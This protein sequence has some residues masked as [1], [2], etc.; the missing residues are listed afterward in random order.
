MISN[1]LFEIRW[2]QVTPDTFMYGSLLKFDDDVTH[3]ENALMPSGVTIHKWRMVTNHMQDKMIP[4]LPIL[5]RNHTYHFKFEYEVIPE[6]SIYFKLTFKRKNGTICDTQI[7]QGHEAIV[8]YPDEA[9]QYDIDMINAASEQ[10]TFHKITIAQEDEAERSTDLEI[11]TLNQKNDVTIPIN[12]LFVESG[13]V[14][15]SA[16][17][18]LPNI[19]VVSHWYDVSVDRIWQVLQ[20]ALNIEDSK[21]YYHFIGYGEQSNIMAYQMAQY[22]KGHALL[23]APIEHMENGSNFTVYGHSLSKDN[24]LYTVAPVLGHHQLRLLNTEMLTG[25]VR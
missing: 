12:V 22:S 25:G 14:S 13:G 17:A 2:T 21:A 19:V 18:H 9:F 7:I 16:I 3:F 23:S 20:E 4:T 10:L 24:P 1:T 6:A 15:E 5:Q 8:H 11:Y